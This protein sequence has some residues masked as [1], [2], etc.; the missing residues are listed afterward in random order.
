M[1][2]R[3]TKGGTLS[4]RL[5]KHYS[6]LPDKQLQKLFHAL[7]REGKNLPRPKPDEIKEWENRQRALIRHADFTDPVLDRCDQDLFRAKTEQPDGGTFYA[8]SHIELRSRQESVLANISNAV[9]LDPPGSQSKYYKLG[10]DGRPTTVWYA[11]YGSNMNKD[12]FLTYIQGGKPEGTNTNHV[13]A[14]DKTLPEEDIPIRFDGRMHF[15]YS[16][17]RWGNGG[18]AFMDVDHAGH[19]LGRAYKITS[20]QFDDV[21]AQEN[22]KTPGLKTDEISFDVVLSTT[23]DEINNGLYG[24]LIHIGDYK[25]A[26]VL[27]F[28]GNFTAQEAIEENS[29]FFGGDDSTRV[30]VASNSPTGNYLRMVHQGLRE[31][32]NLTDEEAADYLRGCAGAE[33]WTRRKLLAVLRAEKP[34]PVPLPK[35]ASP[36]TESKPGLFPMSSKYEPSAASLA[37]VGVS[38]PVSTR[39]VSFS[40]RENYFARSKKKAVGKYAYTCEM[41][42]KG[43]HSYYS[44]P[45]YRESLEEPPLD[46]EQYNKSKKK[47]P[48]KS[49]PEKRTSQKRIPKNAKLEK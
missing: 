6:G 40:D 1:S 21:V 47:K 14:R 44:C 13:G 43:G 5:A 10:E 49:K 8:W 41:C 20:Q 45:L 36:Y 30:L 32:F 24:T 17:S 33:G 27:T 25:C 19:A 35:Y 26:P 38:S 9:D 4:L 12:R 29:K 42:G 7:V 28:T 37:S 11:S 31:T 3:T 34:E 18:V 2:C 39:Q 22:G 16:S 46:Y 23:Q 15:A 48:K